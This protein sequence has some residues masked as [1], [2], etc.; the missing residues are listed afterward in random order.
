MKFV[1]ETN[2]IA[3]F[4]YNTVSRLGKLCVA[5][6]KALIRIIKDVLLV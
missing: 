6:S 2:D 3:V 5:T 4:M 1:Y